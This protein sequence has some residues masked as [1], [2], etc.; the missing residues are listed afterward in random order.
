MASAALQEIGHRPDAPQGA[1]GLRGA[2]ARDRGRERRH[3]RGP[4]ADEHGDAEGGAGE[5][6]ARPD[7][8][9]EAARADASA[10][11]GAAAAAE[12][13][14]RHRRSYFQT[15][16]WV[17]ERRV[18]AAIVAASRLRA[19]AGRRRLASSR[20]APPDRPQRPHRHPERQARPLLRPPRET[21][22]GSSASATATLTV[23]VAASRRN[24]IGGQAGRRPR[25]G[26]PLLDAGAARA[27]RRR[28]RLQQPRVPACRH[29][30]RRRA[31][32]RSRTAA[33]PTWR[34]TPRSPAS[35]TCPRCA[36][37][38]T[39]RARSSSTSSRR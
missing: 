18:K 31:T 39:T 11:R 10:A 36:R 21:R 12:R 22:S 35:P 9:H 19:P 15:R 29:E 2:H 26:R 8:E 38:A 28:A 4:V 23:P 33:R 30:R 1:H 13:R 17:G 27:A 24:L 6:A 32:G 20:G 7:P 16:V 34:R 3:L 37:R 5:Q 25:R 14:R